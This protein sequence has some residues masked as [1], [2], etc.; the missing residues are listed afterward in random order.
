MEA[1]CL[2]FMHFSFRFLFKDLASRFSVSAS[3]SNLFFNIK[4]NKLID[5]QNY[6]CN[7]FTYHKRF[8]YEN[9][10]LKHENSWYIKTEFY[11][12]S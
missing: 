6:H 11:K 12:M 1:A 9:K 2:A 10:F 3:R 8:K 4:T 5:I 7:I